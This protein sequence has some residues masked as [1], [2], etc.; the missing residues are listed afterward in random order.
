MIFQRFKAF[1]RTSP[2][3]IS[4]APTVIT[5]EESLRLRIEKLKNILKNRK[6]PL[7]LL[8]RRYAKDHARIV[9]WHNQ[10]GASM[11]DELC[12]L[13]DRLPQA[14]REREMREIKQLRGGAEIVVPLS[15]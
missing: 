11:W 3:T 13:I 1:K 9:R 14:D 5:P 15:R 10:I 6:A 12:L 2:A 4:Q 7:P 8:H